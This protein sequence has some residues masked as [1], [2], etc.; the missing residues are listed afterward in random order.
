[1][2]GAQKKNDGSKIQ[3]KDNHKKHN[4]GNENPH[5][6]HERRVQADSFRES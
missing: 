1:M 2:G 6:D 4:S 5:G 3:K